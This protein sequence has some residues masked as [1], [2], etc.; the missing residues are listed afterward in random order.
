MQFKHAVS[1]A[2]GKVPTD[3]HQTALGKASVVF[4]ETSSLG[5]EFRQDFSNPMWTLFFVYGTILSGYVVSIYVSSA[6]FSGRL[7][8]IRPVWLWQRAFSYS[9]YPIEDYKIQERWA[10]LTQCTRCG[11]QFGLWIAIAENRCQNRA[12]T[13]SCVSYRWSTCPSRNVGFTQT[14]GK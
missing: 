6:A 4:E 3:K 11:K 1:S 8:P 5:L 10:T 2:Y 9:D 7:S 13:E 12:R 14:A